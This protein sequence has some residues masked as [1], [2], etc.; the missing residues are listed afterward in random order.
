M[1]ENDRAENVWSVNANWLRGRDLNTRPSG[2]AYYFGF[3]RTADIAAD[4]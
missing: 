1:K 3:R 4:S 2:Y